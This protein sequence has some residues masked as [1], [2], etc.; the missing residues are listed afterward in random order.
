MGRLHSYHRTGLAHLGSG[1]SE[2]YHS[3]PEE[4]EEI[5][6]FITEGMHRVATIST[7]D[8][9]FLQSARMAKTYLHRAV[10]ILDTKQCPRQIIH[11]EID[12][13]KLVANALHA[14]YAQFE[15][16]FCDCEQFKQR[17]T[18]GLVEW[19][20]KCAVR[21]VA[22]GE[23]GMVSHHLAHKIRSFHARV[24]SVLTEK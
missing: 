24:C 11:R 6:L 17:E 21:V 1:M 13:L 9:G 7:N 2:Q 10:L 20:S 12:A 8:Y 5:S 22:N 4:P 23:L 18:S 16:F 15:S 14:E 19:C 3:P